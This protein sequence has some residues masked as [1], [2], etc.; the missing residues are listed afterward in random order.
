MYV[1][2]VS[3]LHSAELSSAA[4]HDLRRIP[5][6]WQNILCHHTHSYH[7]RELH[8]AHR[9]LSFGFEPAPE[10]AAS[11]IPA[12]S[13][14]LP[15]FNEHQYCRYTVRRGDPNRDR[16]VHIHHRAFRCPMAIQRDDEPGDGDGDSI[17]ADCYRH[18]RRADF[19]DCDRGIHVY[20]H[21]HVD[22]A[23]ADSL[24]HRNVSHFSQSTEARRTHNICSV[25]SF[26]TT[27]ALMEPS[28]PSASASGQLVG[29]FP[30]SGAPSLNCWTTAW[31]ISAVASLGW[32]LAA[33]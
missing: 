20:R 33:V 7:H 5:C 1:H 26:S 27:T 28:T 25:T 22:G 14:S 29:F 11:I 9:F 24:G 23:R 17:R 31:T 2:T 32:L 21:C 13:E 12:T 4:A 8:R 3:F 16:G 6:Q 18:E 15:S 10:A 19:A 30:V